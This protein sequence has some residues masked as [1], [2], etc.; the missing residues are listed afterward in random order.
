MKAANPTTNRTAP[1]ITTHP[2]EP[3]DEDDECVRIV[4]A[5]KSPAGASV[6]T[7]KQATLQKT[8]WFIE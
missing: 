7:R 3:D 8:R 6:R 1:T 2:H 4:R 5:N